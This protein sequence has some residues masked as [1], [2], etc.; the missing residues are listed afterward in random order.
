VAWVAERLKPAFESPNI[1]K[2]GHHIK[3]DVLVLLQIGIETG[4]IEFDTLL[5]SFVLEPL[6]QS[7]GLDALAKAFFDHDM[8]PLTD[9]IGRGRNQLSLEHADTRRLCEYAGQDADFTWRVAEVLRAQMAGSQVE[10]LF[11][12]TEMRLIEVLVEMENNG[13]ALDPAFLKT[14]GVEMD[15]RLRAL[16]R[17]VH[18]SA[19]REF[20]IDSTK[21][22]AEVL[23]VDLKFPVVRKTKTGRSTDAETLEALAAQTDHPVPKL[24]LEYRELS[25]L[26]NTYVDTLPQMVCTRTGRVH[27]SFHQTG[28]VTGR[29]SSSDPNLQ[30]IPIRTEAGRQIRRAFV[31]G[32]ADAVLLAADYSQIELR[33]LAHFSEDRALIEAFEQGLDIH[34][35][36]AAQV[37]GVPLAEVTSGQR[38]AA[39]AVNFGII[40]GQTPFGLSKAIGISKGEATGFIA[41]YFAR[42]PGIREFIDRCVAEARRKGYAQTILGRRRPI[43]ELHSRNRALVSFGER[44][45]V[46]TVVQGS[47]ADLIKR[48][49][50]DIQGEIKARRLPARML[51]Q[52]HDE[53]VFEAFEKEV[54]AAA[55]IIREKMEHPFQLKVPIVADISWGRTWADTK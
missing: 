52:V 5:A 40:Y 51:L 48:A 45:A 26:K 42:Y 41:A 32:S 18:E 37:N 49:M 34:R 9:L 20:N 15:E 30:N 4:G 7:H 54:E 23:F 22:L 46:N 24:L 6:R 29:L 13:I 25:K 36:V 10:P 8:I 17:Q 14:L 38:S 53:L 1:K 39:K 21:Q 12:D 16:T 28:A 11:R 19:G 27:A 35:A 31:P 44:I 33:L 2:I 50:I 3:Y 47:A 55:R 43:P